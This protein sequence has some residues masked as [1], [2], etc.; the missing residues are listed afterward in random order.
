[1][2][3]EDVIEWG[4]AA[5]LGADPVETCGKRIRLYGIDDVESG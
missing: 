1:V 5:T 3:A 2:A 4:L